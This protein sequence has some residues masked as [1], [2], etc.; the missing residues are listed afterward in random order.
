MS[1]TTSAIKQASQCP[2]SQVDQNLTGIIEFNLM[3]AVYLQVNLY[4]LQ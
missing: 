1:H 4:E 2:Q 3:K